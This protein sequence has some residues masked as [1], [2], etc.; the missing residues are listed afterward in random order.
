M[1]SSVVWADADFLTT[2]S[3]Q[4]N[5]GG[6]VLFGL[7]RGEKEGETSYVSHAM[8]GTGIGQAGVS[9]KSINAAPS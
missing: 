3:T 7:D 6:K 5:L 4:V 8:L 9:L 2:L 1:G